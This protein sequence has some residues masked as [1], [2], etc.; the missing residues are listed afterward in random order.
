MP[1]DVLHQAERRGVRFGRPLKLCAAQQALARRLLT[2][3]TS[4]K[5]VAGLFGVHVATVYRL[6]DTDSA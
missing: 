4:V 5:E 2:E 1:L 3:G 6:A